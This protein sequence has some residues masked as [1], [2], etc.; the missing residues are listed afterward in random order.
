MIKE[1]LFALS[2]TKLNEGIKEGKDGIRYRCL[3]ISIVLEDVWKETLPEVQLNES[4]MTLRT[5]T[6][7]P[8]TIINSNRRSPSLFGHSTELESY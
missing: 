6:G 8:L 4:T 5:Y 7:E 2:S 1:V 3:C